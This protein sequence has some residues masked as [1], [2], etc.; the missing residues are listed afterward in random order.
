[1]DPPDVDRAGLGEFVGDQLGGVEA[2][3][4]HAEE[5]HQVDGLL[6]SR[7]LGTLRDDDN[8]GRLFTRPRTA[9]PRLAAGAGFR[10]SVDHGGFLSARGWY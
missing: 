8:L 10:R 7:A 2:H 4:D 3:L 9:T 5:V 1:M 6:A